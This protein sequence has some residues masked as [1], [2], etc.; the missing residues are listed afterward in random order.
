M[1]RH[2]ALLALE[3]AQDARSEAAEAVNVAIARRNLGGPEQ[4]VANA[5]DALE[6]AINRVETARE[7]Y[8]AACQED[9]A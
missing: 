6:T 3:A 2:N 9:A 8:V 5:W 1:T 4:A 7:G